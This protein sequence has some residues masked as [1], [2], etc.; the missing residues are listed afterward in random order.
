MCVCVCVCMCLRALVR[1]CACVAVGVYRCVCD[2]FQTILT[3]Y[4]DA[5]VSMSVLSFTSVAFPVHAIYVLHYSLV[6][7]LSLDVN[8]I[9]S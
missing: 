4:L 8:L 1:V 9:P 7:L 2:R 3:V 5:C 6:L